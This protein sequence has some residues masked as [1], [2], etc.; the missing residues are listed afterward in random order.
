MNFKNR[1]ISRDPNCYRDAAA[2]FKC[3]VYLFVL[4][5]VTWHGP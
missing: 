5:Q 3:T 2:S 1:K 4:P